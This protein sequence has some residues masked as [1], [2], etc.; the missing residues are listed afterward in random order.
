V[1]S[2]LQPL[3]AAK[4]QPQVLAL[5][6]DLRAALITTGGNKHAVRVTEVA[7]LLAEQIVAARWPASPDGNDAAASVP[8]PADMQPHLETFLGELWQSSA[9]RGTW[10]IIHTIEGSLPL[11]LACAGPEALVTIAQ[12]VT[13]AV[14]ANTA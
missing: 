14:P 5:L 11:L 1:D 10:Q 6:P 8:D 13:S 4:Q 12:S 3:L 9:T 2:L 7:T